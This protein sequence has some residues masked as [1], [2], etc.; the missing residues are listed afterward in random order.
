MSRVDADADH[1][2]DGGRGRRGGGVGEGPTRSK[3]QEKART[4]LER[5]QPQHLP[6]EARPERT[7]DA[8]EVFLEHVDDGLLIVLV[9]L[10]QKRKEAGEAVLALETL[11]LALEP[12]QV[13]R[14]LKDL[15][16]VEVDAVVG[17]T[18]EVDV[19]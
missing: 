1:D 12:R 10:A 17:L 16:V 7:K 3:R 9:G 4:D 15:V 14:E 6:Q 18:C 8:G 2:A 19:A 11:D 13:G 5:M